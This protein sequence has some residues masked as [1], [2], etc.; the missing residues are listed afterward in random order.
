MEAEAFFV[1][2][3]WGLMVPAEVRASCFLFT[4]PFLA[5]AAVGREGFPTQ[6]T[7]APGCW[8]GVLD[9]AG[10][11]EFSLLP[12]HASCF[13]RRPVYARIYLFAVHGLSERTTVQTSSI[14]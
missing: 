7:F 14:L 1:W 11:K 3:G 13:C 8:F 10:M 2:R 4:A 9:G 6:Q 12:G 5:G